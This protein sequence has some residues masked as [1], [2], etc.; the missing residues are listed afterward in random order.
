MSTAVLFRKTADQWE[1]TSEAALETFVCANLPALLGLQVLKQQFAIGGQICDLL[2]VNAHKQLAIVELKNTED[3]YL[4]QQLTRYYDAVTQDFPFSDQV[5][6][7]QPIHLIG[8][9][10]KFHRDNEIDRKYSRLDIQFLKFQL[11]DQDKQL[12]VQLIDID[13]GN[14]AEIAIATPVLPE[15]TTSIENPPTLLLRW[16]GRCS[17]TTRIQILQIR[18]R[19]LRFDSRLQETTTSSQISYGRGVGKPCAELRWDQ[20]RQQVALFLW[21]PHVIR[22]V[23]QRRVVAR[24]RIWS[25]W[26]TVTD[27]GHIPKGFGR[28]ISYGEWLAGNIRPLKSLLPKKKENQ[29]RFFQDE[30]YRNGLVQRYHIYF[31]QNGHHTAP[32]ALSIDE[33]KRLSEQPSLEPSV[34]AIVDLAL[35]TWLRHFSLSLSV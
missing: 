7:A 12:A 24:M 20:T 23:K 16:L 35:Q 9:A 11:L 33:Y 28:K 8:I 15:A 26:N 5:D 14:I 22:G 17:E 19:L 10:P 3:R 21:L 6:Y 18:E 13:T 4:V 29:T 34:D 27:I 1:F 32:L 30:E 25:D 31:R 2:A